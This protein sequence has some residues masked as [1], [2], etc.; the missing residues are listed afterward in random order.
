MKL[1]LVDIDGTLITAPSSE[2]RFA[3]HLR[4]QGRIGMRENLSFAWFALR[5]LPIFGAGVLRKNKAYLA[6]IPED[7][8]RDLA[9]EF[10]NNRLAHALYEPACAKLRHH[11]QIGD[12]VWLLS[13]TLTYIATSLASLL[14]LER[15]RATECVVTDGRLASRPPI[16]HPYGYE[17]LAIAERLCEERG[18]T[19]DQ[20]VAYADSWADRHLLEKA[21]TPVVVM[22]DQKLAQLAAR[23]GWEILASNSTDP[24]PGRGLETR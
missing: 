19:M 10:V 2:R 18:F 6:G 20:V 9:T 1:V 11:L 4:E 3:S 16:V 21:G 7:E 5:Y 22:P 15:V 12:E 13:G 14:R 17:K 23:E 24:A 8:V